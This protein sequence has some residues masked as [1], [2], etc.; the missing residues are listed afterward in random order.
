M[1]AVILHS[2]VPDDARADECDTLIS[3]DSISKALKEL[4]YDVAALSFTLNIESTVKNLKK[5]NPLFVFNLVESVENSGKLIYFAPA[6]LDCFKIPYTGT[7][8]ESMLLTTNK[9]QSK[10]LLKTAGIPTPY[11]IIQGAS[12]E[13]LKKE[14]FPYLIKSVWEHGSVGLEGNYVLSDEQSLMEEMDRR[15]SVADGCWF[16][17]QFIDGREISVPIIGRHAE[18]EFLPVSEIRFEDHYRDKL[19]ILDYKAKWHKETA[20]YQNTIRHFDFPE[21]DGAI[22]E[23]LK[24]L[25]LK[26]WKI[27]GLHGYVRVDFRIDPANNPYVLEINAN[28]CI[29]PDSGF[30]LSAEK[31]GI[32]YNKLIEK[33]VSIALS[34]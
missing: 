31:A 8:A 25:A 18:P 11:W 7:S 16:A 9:I 15:K 24:D 2:K 20:E 27:F 32:N 30:V 1:K 14:D 21:A 29:S 13:D 19:K 10:N 3:V 12:K 17:E 33:I 23:I 26:S 6:F 34:P 28:P 22:L 5:I 4:G